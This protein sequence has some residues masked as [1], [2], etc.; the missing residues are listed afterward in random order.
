M[1]ALRSAGHLSIRSC[2]VEGTEDYGDTFFVFS[3]IKSFK[4]LKG[5]TVFVTRACE[6]A[7]ICS[8]RVGDGAGFGAF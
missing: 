2:V 6:G 3:Q 4:S 8:E 5:F 7:A 1:I